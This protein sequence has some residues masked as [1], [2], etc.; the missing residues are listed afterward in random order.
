MVTLECIGSCPVCNAA[1]SGQ[2]HKGKDIMRHIGTIRDQL[3]RERHP[4]HI[5]R[6]PS[7]SGMAERRPSTAEAPHEKVMV[8]HLGL[9]VSIA[10]SHQPCVERCI[11]MSIASTANS[12]QDPTHL[13]TGPRAGPRVWRRSLEGRS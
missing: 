9:T 5:A 8:Y 12:A 2:I 1:S 10:A 13:L 11:A 6:V 4:M 3:G 7:A